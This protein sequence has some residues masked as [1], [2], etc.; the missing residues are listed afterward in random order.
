MKNTILFDLHHIENKLVNLTQ[1]I[2]GSTEAGQ[3]ILLDLASIR[4]QLHDAKDRIKA[5]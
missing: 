2:D 4:S 1:S 5:I 3:G